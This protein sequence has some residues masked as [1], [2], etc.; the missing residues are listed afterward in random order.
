MP[1]DDDNQL[2]VNGLIWVFWF[3]FFRMAVDVKI[4]KTPTTKA[5]TLDSLLEDSTVHIR[6]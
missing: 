4:R 6:K 5:R 2:F 3:Q 1:Y